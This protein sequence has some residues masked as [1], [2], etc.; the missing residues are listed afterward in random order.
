VIPNLLVTDTHPLLY[1]LGN[2]ERRLSK[3]AKHAFDR[4]LAGELTIFVPVYALIEIS[5]LQKRGRL[6]PVKPLREWASDLFSSSAFVLSPVDLS[7]AVRYDE[8]SF[9]SDP[10]DALIVATA[11]HLGLPLITN[12][13]LIHAAKPCL[14][15]WD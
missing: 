10:A 4:A 9:T 8:T 5:L 12:D 6:Q 1:Y 7:V 15:Y 13:S 11:L 2:N 14:L 3:K